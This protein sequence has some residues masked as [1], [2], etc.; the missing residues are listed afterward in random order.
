MFEFMKLEIRRVLR[1][2]RYLILS[3]VLPLGLYLMY[4]NVAGSSEAVGDLSFATWYMVSMAAFGAIGATLLSGGTRIATD[5]ATGWVK[6]LRA[7][8]MRPSDYLVAKVGAAMFVALP[9]II[10][11]ALA[12]R[13]VNHISLSP[14]SW[15]ELVGFTWLLSL[16]FAILG[17]LLGYLFDADSAHAGTMI[18]YF[19]LAILGG[20]WWPF[21]LMPKAMRYLGEALPSYHFVNVGTHAAAG[22]L[23]RVSDVAVILLYGVLFAALTIW[24]YR[25]D[26]SWQSA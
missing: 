2:R 21:H 6:Q 25:S 22:N 26:R 24:R 13:I 7:T 23:P 9:S 12:G 4:T 14:L 1:N 20:M 18:T 10:L 15:L 5:R 3:I 17:V 16:P 8:P 11:L 19:A